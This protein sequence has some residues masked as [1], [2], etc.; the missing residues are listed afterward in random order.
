MSDASDAASG[1]ASGAGE[2]LREQLRRTF[3]TGAAVALPAV[4]TLAVLAF[5]VNTL[6]NALSPVVGLLDYLGLPT[7]G[8]ELV[9]RAATFV[10]GVL[11]VF[12]VGAVARWRVADRIGDAAERLVKSIPGIGPVYRSFDRMS[13]ALVASDSQ[14]FQ[15]VKLL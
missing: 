11:L 7:D 1:G 9:A 4:V 14:S 10:T 2:R 8:N 15:E 3:V 12:A 13:E 5:A 6:S